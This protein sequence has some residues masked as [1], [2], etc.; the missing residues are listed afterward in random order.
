MSMRKTEESDS[1]V[2]ITQQSQNQNCCVMHS[3]HSR[4]VKIF[5]LCDKISG[6]IETEFKK[7]KPVYQLPEWG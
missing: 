2:C 3:A 4:G 7:L 1:T 6:E 5:E